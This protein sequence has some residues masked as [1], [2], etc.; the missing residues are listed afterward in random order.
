[1]KILRERG[2]LLIFSGIVILII[3]GCVRV[4]V[5]TA[6]EKQPLSEEINQTGNPQQYSQVPYFDQQSE[7]LYSLPVTKHPNVILSS[8]D[9][10]E[11]LS[12]ATRVAREGKGNDFP[13]KVTL[14]R[15]TSVPDISRGTIEDKISDFQFNTASPTLG[16]NVT[17]MNDCFVFGEICSE[18]DFEIMNALEPKGVKVVEE[19]TWCQRTGTAPIAGCSNLRGHSIAVARLCNGPCPIG[20]GVLWLHEFGHNKNLLHRPLDDAEHGVMYP[21]INSR[22]ASLN[23]RE[24]QALRS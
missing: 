9:V 6:G 21:G 12:E 16:S 1:M 2:F 23:E 5:E 24:C 15:E 20:E 3:F 19:I 14:R 11:I 4:K 17:Q 13:C 7:K 22:N 8:Q 10:D 18:F